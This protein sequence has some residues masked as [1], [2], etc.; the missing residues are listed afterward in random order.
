MFHNIANP[1]ELLNTLKDEQIKNSQSNG[2]LV[3]SRQKILDLPR[4]FI[5]LETRISLSI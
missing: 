1:M 5:S 3:S 4:L 2:R